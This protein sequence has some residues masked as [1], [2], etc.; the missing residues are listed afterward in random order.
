[1][2]TNDQQPT[3]QPTT[4][5]A[6]DVY[7]LD[8]EC[9]HERSGEGGPD[10][11]EESYCDEVR[12]ETVCGTHSRFVMAEDSFEELVHAEPWPCK[13]SPAAQPSV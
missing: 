10:G 9:D 2:T 11:L 6:G 1:M 13:H 4:V 8:L 5:L 3:C 7:C 12:E